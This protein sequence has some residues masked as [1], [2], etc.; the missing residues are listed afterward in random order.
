MT[1]A[2]F[3]AMAFFFGLCVLLEGDYAAVLHIPVELD[4]AG[5][6]QQHL[7][8]LAAHASEGGI[9]QLFP[10]RFVSRRVHSK[11]QMTE[12]LCDPHACVM[13][14]SMGQAVV[15]MSNASIFGA[16]AQ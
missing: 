7:V 12:V 1:A 11:D 14:V 16:P 3:W 9:E 13:G 15:D 4:L 5:V 10:G 2:H 8:G 6:G